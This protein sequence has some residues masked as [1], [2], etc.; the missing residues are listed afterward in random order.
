MSSLR[1][2]FPIRPRHPVT[3]QQWVV[4]FVPNDLKA[5]RLPCRFSPFFC[6]TRPPLRLSG[7]TYHHFATIPSRHTVSTH[8]EIKTEVFDTG[9]GLTGSFDNLSSCIPT[10][11]ARL[12][13]VIA[14]VCGLALCDNPSCLS[15]TNY[16]NA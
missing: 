3:T 5:F 13:F 1:S 4:T 6:E 2:M 12:A 10:E 15:S 7:A 14:C 9:D 16:P 8:Q 11:P